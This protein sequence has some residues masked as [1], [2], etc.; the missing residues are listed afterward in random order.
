VLTISQARCDAELVPISNCGVSIG[1]N[2]FKILLTGVCLFVLAGGAVAQINNDAGSETAKTTLVHLIDLSNRNALRTPEARKLFVGEAT[3]WDFPS[4]GKLAAAPD[5]VVLIDEKGA[6]ARVQWHGENN[7][8]ADLYFYLAFYGGWKIGAVRRLSLT[9]IIELAY[10]GL[11]ARKTLTKEEQDE[12]SNM[13]LLLAPD[14]V[15]RAWF[16]KQ[17]PSMNALSDLAQS[18]HKGEFVFLNEPDK[19]YPEIRQLLRALHLD[20]VEVHEDGNV[21]I[22]I[23]GVTDNTVGFIYSPS[24]HPPGIDP[25]SYIWVE[26][27]ADKWYLFRTT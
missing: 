10:N 16:V 13:E 15:L 9:G 12:L 17:Q 3:T 23:G 22:V 6:V 14:E 5:T 20:G 7:Y 2:S 24:N 4:F 19:S 25:K 11:K 27:V 8:V 18:M 26:K 21:E 1:V